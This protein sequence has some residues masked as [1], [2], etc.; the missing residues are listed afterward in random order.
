MNTTNK[1]IKTNPTDPKTE[2]TTIVVV[3][4]DEKYANIFWNVLF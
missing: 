1:T 4:S 2:A 3:E